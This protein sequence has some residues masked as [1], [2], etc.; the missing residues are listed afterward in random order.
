MNFGF[1]LPGLPNAEATNANFQNNE[2]LDQLGLSAASIQKSNG[3]EGADLL[4]TALAQIASPNTAHHTKVALA[5]GIRGW[6]TAAGKELATEAVVTNHTTMFEAIL[7]V[8]MLADDSAGDYSN[9]AQLSAQ[10]LTLV[11]LKESLDNAPYAELIVPDLIVA[12][13]NTLSANARLAESPDSVGRSAG[14]VRAESVRNLVRCFP[15]IGKPC[16]D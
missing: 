8:M 11:A 16:L 6:Q 2:I 10:H 14:A 13:S 3:Q 15:K 7:V 1:S 4:G 12:L 9:G 5:G